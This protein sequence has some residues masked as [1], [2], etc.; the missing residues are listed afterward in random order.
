MSV[1]TMH[2]VDLGLAAMLAGGALLFLVAVWWSW[3]GDGVEIPR[4]RWPGL[5]RLAA[6]AGWGLVIGGIAAQIAGFLGPVGVTRF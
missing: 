2:M 4:E 1:P 3:A 5:T 6:V